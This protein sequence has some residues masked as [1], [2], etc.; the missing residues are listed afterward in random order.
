[1]ERQFWLDRW[2]AGQI[3][4]HEG[5]PNAYLE[6]HAAHLG[7]PGCVLVPLCGKSEDLAWLASRGHAVLGVE[8]AERGARA[9]FAEHGLVPA[10]ARRGAYLALAAGGVTILVG[11]VFDLTPADVAAVTAF[12]DRAA[13]IALTPPQRARYVALLRK[14]L[15]GSNGLLVT[16]EYDARLMDPPPHAVLEPE[17][18]ALYA[19]VRVA[20]IDDGPATHARLAAVHGSAHVRCFALTL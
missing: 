18:R 3:G 5:R 4:F 16:F 19:G 10:E 17:V 7:P 6:R 13:L 1:V 8:L 11:D 14:L 15:P 9:F 12:Y 2:N 20:E